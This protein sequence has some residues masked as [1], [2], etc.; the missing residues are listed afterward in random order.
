VLESKNLRWV[1]QPASKKALATDKVINVS[2]EIFLPVAETEPLTTLTIKKSADNVLTVPY[3]EEILERRCKK[4]AQEARSALEET[5]SH[6]LYLAIGFLIWYEDK[7]SPE[8]NQ[9]PL[10]L[11]PVKLERTHLPKLTTYHC[12]RPI[13][14]WPG[15][16]KLIHSILE[17]LLLTTQNYQ[18]YLD[19]LITETKIPLEPTLN[20]LQTLTAIDVQLLEQLPTDFEASIALALL[21]PDTLYLVRQFYRQQQKYHQLFKQAIAILK[22]EQYP[23]ASLQQLEQ[24]TQ[25][26][27]QLGFNNESP[28][29]LNFFLA[30]VE[31]IHEK[32]QSLLNNPDSVANF[33]KFLQLRQLANQAP[34]TLILNKH[35]AHA[36][37]TTR[38]IFKHAQ[39]TFTQLAKQ[40][41]AQES[42]F[43]LSKL[44]AAKQI[45]PLVDEL[46]RYKANWLAWL[47]VDY[48]QTKKAI[49]KF[50]VAPHLFNKRE[51]LDKL[52]NLVVLKRQLE[53]ETQ[54]EQYQQLFGPLFQGIDTDWNQLQQHLD[55]AQQ[56]SEVLGSVEQAQEL[57]ATQADPCGYLLKST[58]VIY[59][60]WLRVTKVAEQLKVSF[61]FH[62]PVSEFVGK[63]MARRRWLLEIL[64]LWQQW[65]ILTNK[66]IISIQGAVRNLLTAWQLR[67]NNQHHSVLELFMGNAFIGIETDI[68]RWIAIADWLTQLQTIG[69]LPLEI[70]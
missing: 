40:W 5:G 18:A 70:T 60:Q 17:T 29:E 34:P 43:L 6:L 19:N 45:A 1:A 14:I 62:L 64:P 58:A 13:Q 69:N 39:Q 28:D 61:D 47:S 49:K 59:E 65:P 22:H 8:P 21:N 7:N 24:V 38:L 63:I 3:T 50:L 4:L 46:R 66:P 20:N 10:I 42:D 33:P 54:R 56:L 44:P 27:R 23:L 53:Q 15:D 41:R 48:R 67:D 26:L 52:A 25:Q 68:T 57:L 12:F 51:L 30:S 35:P 36:L 37:E 9:A 11:I 32:L 2:R 55:W 16:E 31:R